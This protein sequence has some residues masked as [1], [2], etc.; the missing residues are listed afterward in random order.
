APGRRAPRGGGAVRACDRAGR[1]DGTAA[2]ARRAGAFAPAPRRC[3]MGAW[4]H[5]QRRARGRGRARA[6]GRARPNAA[7]WRLAG[8]DTAALGAA[9]PRSARRGPLGD[10]P[11]RRATGARARRSRGAALPVLYRRAPLAGAGHVRDPAGGEP[12]RARRAAWAEVEP[13]LDA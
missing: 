6:D 13:L 10:A 3:A 9:G 4:R 7:D 12:L 2:S 11:P 8:A 5:P 1:P